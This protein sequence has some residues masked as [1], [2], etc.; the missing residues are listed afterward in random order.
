MVEKC[1]VTDMADFELRFLECKKYLWLTHWYNVGM[2]SDAIDEVWHQMLLTSTREYA[3]FCLTFF[4][5][6]LHH[7]AHDETYT[8][9]ETFAD[10]VRLYE[11]HFGELPQ[12]WRITE[13]AK[14]RHPPR[15]NP[16]PSGCGK[17]HCRKCG[18]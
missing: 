16:P 17:A 6:F 5:E 10:F 13:D 3:T 7:E 8:E 11:N 4:G 18:G 9:T 2:Y 15:C 1:L 14:C 12:V